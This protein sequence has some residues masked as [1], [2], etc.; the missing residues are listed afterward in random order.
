MWLCLHDKCFGAVENVVDQ[1]G[2]GRF[3]INA[4]QSFCAPT[5]EK[6]PRV[7]S[8]AVVGS[9][10]VELDAVAFLLTQNRVSGRVLLVG[11]SAARRMAL[12]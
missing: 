4:Q 7:G 5:R 9:I 3:D 6:D 2:R 12:T 10:E 1:F 11:G 8:I